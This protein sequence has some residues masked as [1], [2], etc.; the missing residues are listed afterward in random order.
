M[1]ARAFASW[2]AGRMETKA[3]SVC[4]QISNGLD[5]VEAYGLADDAKDFAITMAESGNLSG[6]ALVGSLK[7]SRTI[8]DMDES[9]NVQADHLAEAFGFR[10]SDGIGGF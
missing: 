8:A 6:R 5:S 7:V 3:L 10:M 9:E 2:R 4:A 1:R